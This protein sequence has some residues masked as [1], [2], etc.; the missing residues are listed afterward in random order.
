MGIQLTKYIVSRLVNMDTFSGV[1]IQLSFSAFAGG[2]IFLLAVYL[3]KSEEFINFR[4]SLTRRLLRGR[5]VIVEDIGDVS[6]IN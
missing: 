6:G 1:F 3:L 5:K 4:E 2:S